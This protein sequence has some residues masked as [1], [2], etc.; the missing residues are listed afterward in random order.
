MI[1]ERS[2]ASSFPGFWTELLPMLTPRFVHMINSGSS[3]A[4]ESRYGSL[5]KPIPKNPEIIDNSVVAEFAFFLAQNAI[6]TEREVDDI[7]Q[8]ERLR[9]SIESFAVELVTRYKGGKRHSQIKLEQP[10]LNEGLALAR[11]YKFFLEKRYRNQAI[12]FGPA[13]PGAGYLAACRADL[14]VGKVLIEIKTVDRNLASKDIKQLI[15]YL[16]LQA[17]TGRRRWTTAGFFNPRRATYHEFNIDEL[18]ERMSGGR[19]ATE[20]FQDLLDFVCSR[21]FQLDV[22]F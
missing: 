16:A 6:Q 13:I 11:N 4:L 10:D 1:S 21:D 12:E 19:S 14:S 8:D 5:L 18:I 2:F 9:E 22:A 15:V 20:V 17:S 3:S 7:F